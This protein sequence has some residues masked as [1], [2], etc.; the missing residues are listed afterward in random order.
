MSSS[1]CSKGF[2][3]P[4]LIIPSTLV[5]SVGIL[6]KENHATE[7]DYKQV[8]LLNNSKCKRY[9]HNCLKLAKLT[10]T[11]SKNKLYRQCN[12]HFE[13]SQAFVL[14]HFPLLEISVHYQ[15]TCI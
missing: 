12:R 13:I 8:F 4:Y 5:L 2:S 6:V 11:G 14:W 1:C 7:A 3:W 15:C 9:F 10:W